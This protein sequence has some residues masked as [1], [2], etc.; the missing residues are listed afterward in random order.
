MEIQCITEGSTPAYHNPAG[1]GF[2]PGTIYLPT[3]SVS[4]KKVS[5]YNIPIDSTIR[6][7]LSYLGTS[8]SAIMFDKGRRGGKSI[9]WT[10]LV[11]C[12][13]YSRWV[14]NFIDT[15]ILP[16]EEAEEIVNKWKYM[17]SLAGVLPKS[18][19]HICPRI[20]PSR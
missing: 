16:S 2:R 20:S 4:W 12:L 10:N 1:F 3:Y 15:N 5:A 13:G 7:L 11:G 6:G 18:G 8:M 19:L 14:G 17:S 9:A